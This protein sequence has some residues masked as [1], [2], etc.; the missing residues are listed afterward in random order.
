MLWKKK[1]IKCPIC[2]IVHQELPAF[3]FPFPYY[4]NILSEQDK[5]ELAEIND[6]FCI[7]N[8][9]EQVDRFIR[10]NLRIQINDACE[11]LDYG[12]WVSLSEKS[13]NDYKSE[14]KDNIGGKLYFGMI[15]NE[16]EDYNESTLGLHVNV[17]TKS[18]GIRPEIIP[19]QADHQLIKEWEH[20]L[21]IQEARQ[22]I[23]KLIKSVG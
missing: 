23:E 9:P 22:R 1:N 16:I 8:H 20:G 21:T 18:N 11:D 3:G 12:I 6:D 15:S 4:Y 10:T 7:I 2:G 14:F 5:Q 19:H 17:V 13:F